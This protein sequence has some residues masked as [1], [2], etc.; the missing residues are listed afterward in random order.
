VTTDRQVF[1]DAGYLIAL[2]HSRDQHHD[3]AVRWKEFVE[4]RNIRLLTSDFVLLEFVDFLSG[5]G[6]RA[7]AR[8][9]ALAMRVGRDVTVVPCSPTLLDRAL[10][11]HE[12]RDDKTWSL[13]DCTSIVTMQDRGVTAALSFDRDFVQAGLRVLPLEPPPAEPWGTTR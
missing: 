12:R 5:H 2:L 10:M 3:E 11:L 6:E 9:L 4:S 7:L 13:T 8:E 1:V